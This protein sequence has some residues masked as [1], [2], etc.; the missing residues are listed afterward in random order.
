VDSISAQI[1]A[2]PMKIGGTMKNFAITGGD[3]CEPSRVW[4][5]LLSVDQ[6]SPDSFKWPSWLPIQLAQLGIQWRDISSNPENFVL[7]ISA[8][9]EQ[10]SR[11][12]SGFQRNCRRIED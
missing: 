9:V 2:G 6:A 10:S 11:P 5:Q 7:T 8:S 12:T 1:K 4:G 3:F